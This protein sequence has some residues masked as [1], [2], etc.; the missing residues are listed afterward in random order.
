MDLYAVLPGRRRDVGGDRVI[1][2]E[3][4]VKATR[5]DFCGGAIITALMQTPAGHYIGKRCDRCS[6]PYA[7]LSHYFPTHEEAL[8]ALRDF[9]H[10]RDWMMR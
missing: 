8:T 7:R 4:T 1:P 3:T 9:R 6:A 5:C 2:G 10:G